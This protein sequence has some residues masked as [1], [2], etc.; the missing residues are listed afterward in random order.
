MLPNMANMQ[1]HLEKIKRRSHFLSCE[2]GCL[3]CG[4]QEVLLQV[5]THTGALFPPQATCEA[6]RSFID[7]TLGR[8]L[9]NVTTAAT[10]C[11]QALCSSRGRCQRKDPRSGAY[12]HLD[13]ASWKVVS[14]GGARAGGGHRAVG[15]MGAQEARRMQARFE[16]Q[17]FQGWTGES[18]SKHTR[19]NR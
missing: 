3:T 16:C 5:N 8:Y 15:Q 13:P 4:V 2:T 11:S 12:L 6:L 14:G 1:I 10:L 9:V 17:C 18:C 19:D 7:D